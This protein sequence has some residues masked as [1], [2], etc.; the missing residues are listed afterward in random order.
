[1]SSGT[2]LTLFFFE[3]ALCFLN[4]SESSEA[5]TSISKRRCLTSVRRTHTFPHRQLNLLYMGAAKNN[6]HTQSQCQT[7]KGPRTRN[8]MNLTFKNRYG[9]SPVRHTAVVDLLHYIYFTVRHSHFCS[10]NRMSN[11]TD[12][13]LK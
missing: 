4:V 5:G 9:T 6:S 2:I 1:M 13:S 10:Q 3:R 11:N 8:S 7:R 12:V